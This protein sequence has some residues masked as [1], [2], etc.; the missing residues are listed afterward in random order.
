MSMDVHKRYRTE[1]HQNVTCRFN[2]RLILSLADCERCLLVND[3]LTVLP[4]SS[5]TADIKTVDV[6]AVGS[7]N[8]GLLNELKENLRDTPPAGPLVSL[9][10]TYDQAKAVAQF[11]DAL[12]EKE[13]KPPTSLTAGRGRGKSAAMGLSMAAAIAFNYVNV[14]VTSPHPEN[15]ITL[16][17]FVLKGFDA[18]EY[19]EHTDYTIIRSTNPDFKKAII[20]INI[21]R[22]GRQTIQYIAPTDGHLLNAADLVV[23]DEAAAI[24]L[25]L[26]KKMLGPYLVFMASTINGYEGTGRSL[27]LKL[28]SQIQ[29]DSNAPPPIKLDES[30][31]YRPN[32]VIEKWL[33]SLLC[34]DAS[35]IPHLSSGCPPPDSCELYYIDRDA[36]FSYHR[37]AE[38][39]LQR[40]VS[41]YVSSHYKNSP[42]DLQMMSD[43]P[44]HHLFCLLGPVVKKD[45]LPEI[46]VV[47]QVCFEGEISSESVQNSLSRGKKAAGDLIPWN[48]SEQF[49]DRDFPKLAGARIVRI[50]THPNYQRVTI[51]DYLKLS[52]KSVVILIVLI[53]IFF[54]LFRWVT[55]RRR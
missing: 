55:V 24:P 1:A 14:Y 53:F 32:D 20:R 50:A 28:L 33:T 40:I 15:L 12:A 34:L 44:A 16:F 47:I 49:N 7:A 8:D 52:H 25:P 5:K 51:A 9:C 31:R 6:S 38:A 2:E 39:F 48:I 11:I 10:K 22:N 23:I 43:A 54:S 29:K 19:Q 35:T 26:I 18:L 27:S 36:L 30:I 45:A 46:F 17:E 42:N 21:T 4:L 13:L 41:I 3:D 37:A